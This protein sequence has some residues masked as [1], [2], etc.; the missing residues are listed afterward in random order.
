MEIK[1][2]LQKIVAVILISSMLFGCVTVRPRAVEDRDAGPVLVVEVDKILKVVENWG[3]QN[4]FQYVAYRRIGTETSTEGDVYGNQYG[5]YGS[6]RTVYYSKVLVMGINSIEDVPQNYN[7]TTVP[8]ALHTEM[9][10]AGS[11]LLGTGI[12]IGLCLLLLIPLM[13]ME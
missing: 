9:T 1:V 5:F 13:N 11:Y 7:V 10:E 8:S 3:F 2:K 12:G 4:G 6:S